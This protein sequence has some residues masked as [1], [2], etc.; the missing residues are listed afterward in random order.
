[1]LRRLRIAASVFFAAV[2]V[3]LCVLWVRSYFVSEW[4]LVPVSGSSWVGPH[5]LRGQLILETRS[6][7]SVPEYG[8]YPWLKYGSTS[9]K[10]F[11]PLEKTFLGFG[12]NRTQRGAAIV[13]PLWFL[14]LV[15]AAAAGRQWLSWRFSLRTML[16]A[17]TL[18]AVAL[19]LAVRAGR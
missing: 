15:A 6:T 16:L 11:F 18:A 5:S 9:P 14:V 2:A 7:P 1:M 17:M 10:N 12:Q 4:V 13:I 19:W 8:P 3:A